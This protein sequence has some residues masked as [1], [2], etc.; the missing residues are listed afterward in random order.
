VQDIKNFLYNSFKNIFDELQ[1]DQQPELRITN[2]EGF[3]MQLNNLLRIRDGN[4]KSKL[5]DEI[6]FI[7]NHK[8]IE[9]LEVTN[10]GFINLK[11]SDMY[12]FEYIRMTSNTFKEIIKTENPKSFLL[13]YGGMNIGKAM[14][15][16]H[17]RS[18]NIGRGIKNLL[19]AAGHKVV[20]DIHLGD[21]GMPVAQILNFCYLN[22]IDIKSISIEDLEEIYPKA[23]ELSKVDKEFFESSQNI[24]KKLNSKDP[25]IYDGWNHIYKISTDEIKRT[26]SIFDHNFDIFEGESNAN[27]YIDPL[28]KR[29]VSEEL[30]FEDEGAYITSFEDKNILITKSDGSY[31]YITTDLGTVVRREENLNIDKYIYIVDQRQKQHFEDLFKCVKKFKLSD[32]EFLHIGYG[33]INNKD[34]RPLKTRDGGSYKLT[35]LYKDVKDKFKNNIEN[36]DDLRHLTNSVLTYSDLQTNKITDYKFDLDKFTSVEGNTAVYLQ[37]TFARSNKVLRDHILEEVEMTLPKSH[38]ETDQMLMREIIKLPEKFKLSEKTLELNHLADYAYELSKVFNKFYSNNKIV[39]SDP[40][41][42]N[43]RLQLTKQMNHTLVFIFNLLGIEA[44]EKL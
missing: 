39:N 38:N 18:L 36:K 27:D 8:W 5:L 1:I 2:F 23:S 24:N 7:E 6:K 21:W 29:L 28:I 34:G 26:L 43:F 30:I 32:S 3:D 9:H 17:I 13:D 11:Y 37:Y 41:L 42:M 25:T 12:V 10:N 19:S 20:S 22:K 40:E 33:T 31:L 35:D 16:G 14:H 15:V 44:V 4:T